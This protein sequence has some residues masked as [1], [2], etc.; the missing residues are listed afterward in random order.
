MLK[1]KENKKRTERIVFLATK[2]EKEQL[3][4][5]AESKITTLSMLIRAK[6][7]DNQKQKSEIV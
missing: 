2:E 1:A 4:K 5:E 3:I 6:L 7:F